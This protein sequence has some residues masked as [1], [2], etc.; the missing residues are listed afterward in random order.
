MV[1]TIAGRWKRCFRTINA[2]RRYSADRRVMVDLAA[3]EA[4]EITV[5]AAPLC[6]RAGLFWGPEASLIQS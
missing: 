5:L 4:E 3:L 2:K 6:R 1:S